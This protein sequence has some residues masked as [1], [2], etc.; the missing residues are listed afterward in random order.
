MYV[1]IQEEE[2]ALQ[3]VVLLDQHLVGQSAGPVVGVW[4]LGHKVFVT[5]DMMRGH[6]IGR[7]DKCNRREGPISVGSSNS[8]SSRTKSGRCKG[9]EQ[10]EGRPAG[11]LDV[12][13]HS[14]LNVCLCVCVCVCERERERERER[15]SELCVCVC[16]RERERER[17]S[18]V[19]V[20]V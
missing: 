1:R 16:E 2:G 6:A 13:G 10:E 5:V 11:Q 18:C 15:E 4:V 3:K 8:C 17:E 14:Q 12:Q 20:C 7:P 19:C 9:E